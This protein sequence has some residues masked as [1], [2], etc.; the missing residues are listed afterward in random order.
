MAGMQ[1]VCVGVSGGNF[2]I[3]SV[4]LLKRIFLKFRSAV[5]W[6]IVLPVTASIR[7]WEQCWAKKPTRLVEI[8]F[9]R[10][11]T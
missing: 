5:M 1:R 9:S 10:K 2:L 11:I 4:L 3:S 6:P 7:W 8:F